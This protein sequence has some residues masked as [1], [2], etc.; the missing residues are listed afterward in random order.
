M[1][2]QGNYFPEDHDERESKIYRVVK[3]I[4]K[5]TMYG[6]SFLIYGIIFVTLFLNRDSKILEKN[7]LTEISGFENIDTENIQL[8][9][10][11]ARIFM[12]EDGSLE[13]SNINYSQDY[14]T[15][16]IG[17][18]FNGKKLTN[19]DKGDCL[20]YRLYDSNGTEYELAY[21]KSDSRGRY[22]FSRVCFQGLNIDLDSNDI[23]YDVDS[24][25]P[26]T[27]VLYKLDVTRKSD[28]ELLY[29]FDLY[30]NKATFSKTDYND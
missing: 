20:N 30:D 2:Y 25:K 23:R 15:I 17:V 7:Y 5:W 3:G 14:G 22:G 24:E 1:D 8:Y 26:R 19:G 6:I 11:N 28:G 4:F 16:E 18:K 21:L 10:I 29:S 13:L 12:N 9:K 27:N